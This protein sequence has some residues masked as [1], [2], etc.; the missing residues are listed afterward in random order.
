MNSSRDFECSK[1]QFWSPPR[2]QGWSTKKITTRVLQAGLT[3]QVLVL[4]VNN[5]S[6]FQIL[7]YLKI[8][9][10]LI[11]SSLLILNDSEIPVWTRAVHV[12]KRGVSAG[13]GYLQTIHQ[14]FLLDCFYFISNEFSQLVSLL[15]AISSLFVLKVSSCSDTLKTSAW[16]AFVTQWASVI[17]LFQVYGFSY[18]ERAYVNRDVTLSKWRRHVIEVSTYLHPA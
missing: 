4:E 10:G 7:Q 15:F 13:A 1:L 6:I 14:S 18:H 9:H 3:S 16:P 12:L 2:Y 17:L 5:R 11:I 8:L